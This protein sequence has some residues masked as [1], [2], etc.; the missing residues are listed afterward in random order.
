MA[1]KTETPQSKSKKD[2]NCAIDK[3]SLSLN[4]L[5]QI[6]ADVLQ[7]L[8]AL[9]NAMDFNLSTV[10]RKRKRGSGIKRYGFLDKVSDVASDN[11]QFAPQMFSDTALK[12]ILRR[13]EE[14]R[15][16]LLA[17]NQFGRTINDL[18]LIAGD[19]A[20]Q[21]ALIYYNS[22]RELARRRVPG[23]EQ[24]FRILQ[25]FFRH[26]RRPDEEPTEEE[27]ETDV[28][29]LLH[30]KKDGKIV[31]EHEKPHLV[32]GKHVVIDETHKDKREFKET[33]QGEIN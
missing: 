27:V 25:P 15:N 21:L 13:I 19:E 14:L 20:F 6:K 5:I 10:E 32:G 17:I 9:E 33:E 26:G 24:T 31:I 23:A 28:R 4:D 1:K 11:M 16:I 12:N 2:E 8:D 22:V 29:A 30:G 3:S 7:M 18:L